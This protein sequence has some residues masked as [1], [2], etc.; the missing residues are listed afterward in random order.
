MVSNIDS[1]SNNNIGSYP[2]IIPYRSGQ[3]MLALLLNGYVSTV[4]LVISGI[5]LY[6]WAHNYMV[7]NGDIG[8]D[9]TASSQ[10]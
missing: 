10:F 7:A 8:L 3:I 4:V 6:V 1:C 5:D 9:H 2:D